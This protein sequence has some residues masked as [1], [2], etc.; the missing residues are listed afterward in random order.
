MG[1][2]HELFQRLELYSRTQPQKAALVIEDE[3]ISYKALWD[4]ITRA[5]DVKDNIKT[6]EATKTDNDTNFK[7][8][9]N[10]ETTISNGVRYSVVELI[11]TYNIKSQLV[12]WLRAI[13]EG[14]RP[15]ICHA[16]LNEKRR[17]ELL[18]RYKLESVD[19]SLVDKGCEMAEE[20]ALISETSSFYISKL[21]IPEQ[22]SF[23]VLTSGTTGLPK[24]LWRS[25]RSWVDFFDE[26]N[27]VFKVQT[28]S[29]LFIH[30][31]MSFTGNLNSLLA[32]L[33]AGGTTIVAGV[34]RPKRWYQLLVQWGVTHMYVLPTKLRMLLPCLKDN[35]STLQLIFTGSQL[36][37][38]KLVLNL[39]KKQPQTECILY[40]GASELNY[41]TYCTF[42][43]WLEEPNTVGYAFKGVSVSLDEKSCIKV[44]TPYGIE[45]IDR[46]FSV[47]DVGEFSAT[48]RL[49]FKGRAD[50]IINR[51]GYKLSLPYLESELL[52]VD[53]IDD[54]VVLAV[55]DDL[56]GAQPVAFIVPT[57][58]ALAETISRAIHKRFL[59]KE[60]PK[61]IFW[62]KELPLTNA[63]KIDL[64][65]LRAL[66]EE[67]AEK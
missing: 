67:R 20:E 35:V 53:G 33:Y 21:A 24:V 58:G 3:V 31:S 13:Y 54:V 63:S 66:Y 1:T 2:E 26:Q 56:R 19:Y 62:L 61:H 32:M 57:E 45:G 49:Y 64:G 30:G 38:Y 8:A 48:G 22:A 23:G 50:A 6:N 29:I 60:C 28:E 9:T 55:D 27:R 59:P 17:G 39:K 36:L 4:E 37:D 25:L 43:E 47:G 10:S 12:A 15:I 46:P 44:D 40:Y 14:R 41:I 7:T 16:D 42:D 51:G 18:T 11:Q 65:A 34:L 5:W 52:C